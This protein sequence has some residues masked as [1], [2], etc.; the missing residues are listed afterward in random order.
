MSRI[1]ANNLQCSNDI[2][3]EDSKVGKNMR[4]C[5]LF[6]QGLIRVSFFS[7]TFQK[8]KVP[9]SQLI[10]AP[11]PQGGASR[12]RSGEPDASQGSFVHIVP[13]DLAYPALGG[14]G[15][16]PVKPRVFSLPNDLSFFCA[17][18]RKILPTSG[19]GTLFDTSLKNLRSLSSR[20]KTIFKKSASLV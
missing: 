16:V 13:L 12:A 2:L 1:L 11:R 5:W 3:T 14:T 6:Q 4:P 17:T 8:G 18:F 15:H 19:S 10:E 9:F 20:I 7:L